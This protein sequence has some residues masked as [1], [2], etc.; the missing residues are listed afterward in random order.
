MSSEIWVVTDHPIDYPHHL[1]V[2][3]QVIENGRIL[4]AFV[5]CLYRR[6]S[7][8]RAWMRARGLTRTPPHDDDPPVVVE[9]WV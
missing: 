9:V 6:R 2:R 8:V 7:E 1:V 5:G 4:Q 3:R